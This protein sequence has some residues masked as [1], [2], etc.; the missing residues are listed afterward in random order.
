MCFP[1]IPPCTDVTRSKPC[2]KTKT[3]FIGYKLTCILKLTW[4]SI[5][6]DSPE[7]IRGTAFF[8]T[9]GNSGVKYKYLNYIMIYSCTRVLKFEGNVKK[10][11][12]AVSPS[13]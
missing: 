3:I 5:G 9:S 7:D 13:I 10:K 8:G 11:A 4:A 6:T 12:L 1:K 2:L